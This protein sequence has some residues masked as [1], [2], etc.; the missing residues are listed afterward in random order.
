MLFLFHKRGKVISNNANLREIR[1]VNL[2]QQNVI[3][4]LRVSRELQILRC[5]DGGKDQLRMLSKSNSNK[6]DRAE[7][8]KQDRNDQYF[9]YTSC[10]LQF[11]DD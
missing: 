1:K 6:Q 9:N 8:M 10:N 7:I 2:E 3:K 4:T 11:E 5:S